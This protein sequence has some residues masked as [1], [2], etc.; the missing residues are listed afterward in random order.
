MLNLASGDYVT[1]NLGSF[2]ATG[3]GNTY[4]YGTKGSRFFGHLVA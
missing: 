1:F 3:S 4:L 2:S